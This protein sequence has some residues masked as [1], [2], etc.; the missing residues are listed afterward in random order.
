MRRRKLNF[1]LASSATII[2]MLIYTIVPYVVKSRMY[3]AETL[4]ILVVS[5]YTFQGIIYT[6]VVCWCLLPAMG[7]LNTDMKLERREILL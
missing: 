6:V 1:W 5:A 2:Y 7:K 3:Y 4:Q